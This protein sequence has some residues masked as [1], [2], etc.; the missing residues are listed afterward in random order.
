MLTIK[1][2][3][4]LDYILFVGY[5]WFS[6]RVLSSE[7]ISRKK[8]FIPSPSRIFIFSQFAT[9]KSIVAFGR[10]PSR[11]TGYCEKSP[12]FAPVL[13]LKK[14]LGMIFFPSLIVC[15]IQSTFWGRACMLCARLWNPDIFRHLWSAMC[16]CRDRAERCEFSASI[17]SACELC[18][19]HPPW[20]SC[21][22]KLC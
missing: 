19:Y 22:T 20:T 12:R 11:R 5:S 17:S 8:L 3:E 16:G 21:R 13:F 4:C 1:S 2:T 14:I 6:R 18:R 7:I 10:I 15:W 9:N